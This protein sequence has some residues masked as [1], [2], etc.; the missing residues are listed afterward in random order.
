MAKKKEAY[1]YISAML[2]ARET[3]MLSRDKA[4]RMLDAQSFEDAAK[5]LTDCGY[6][7]MSSMNAKQIEN[8]LS[9][10]RDKLFKE[11]ASCVPD[12]AIVD[13]FRVKYDYHNAKVLIKA[14]AVGSDESGLLSGSGRVSP[15]QLKTAYN[16]DKMKDLP[17]R[18]GKALGEAKACLSRTANPQLA[19]FVLDR[20]Y[21]GELGD[22]A[23]KLESRYLEKYA[24]VLIDS[25]NLR[26]AVR[27]LRMGKGSDFMALSL[28]EGGNVSCARILNETNGEGLA[29]VFALSSLNKAAQLGAAAINGGAMTEFELACDNA[30]MAYVSDAKLRAYGEEPVIAYM[31]AV[32]S[33]ITAARMILTGRLAGIAPDVIRER[34]RDLYA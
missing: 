5:I 6:E 22:L 14:E 29:S 11:L 15:Q 30:V 8:A 17:G 18:L 4:E 21:F 13:I 12:K 16:E 3:K 9:A 19:D 32:E 26:S 33:E 25:T 31:A 20:E 34:L 27:T 28:V 7:D 2:R 1:L 10:H 23:K 24:A